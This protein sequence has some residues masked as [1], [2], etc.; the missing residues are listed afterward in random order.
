MPIKYPEDLDIIINQHEHVVTVSDRLVAFYTLKFDLPV[1][2][3]ISQ[4]RHG[5]IKVNIH[6]LFE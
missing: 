2:Q 5:S 3:Y 4:V 1:L 6:V